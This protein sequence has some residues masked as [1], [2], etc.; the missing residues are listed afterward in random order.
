MTDP[1]DDPE[2]AAIMEF[3]GG[4]SRAEAEAAAAIPPDDPEFEAKLAAIM[5]ADDSSGAPVETPPDSPWISD[6]AR[7]LQRLEWEAKAARNAN[8]ERKGR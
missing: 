5:G 3:D 7:D 2:R 8:D 4:L 1:D 6:E